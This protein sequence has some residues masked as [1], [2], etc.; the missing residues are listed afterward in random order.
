MQGGRSVRGKELIAQ[1]ARKYQ[2]S[3]AVIHKWRERFYEGGKTALPFENGTAV[4]SRS[5]EQALN[6]ARAADRGTREGDWSTSGRDPFFKKTVEDVKPSWSAV[7]AARV[8]EGM[9]VERAMQLLGMSRSSYYRQVRGMVDY[10]PRPRLRVSVQH[11]DVLR[12]VALKLKYLTTGNPLPADFLK[13]T[14]G[15]PTILLVWE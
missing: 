7:E 13:R 2:V 4:A 8:E 3:D 15:Q 5:R 1:I 6:L 10:T 12:D 14:W 9:R 11:Q